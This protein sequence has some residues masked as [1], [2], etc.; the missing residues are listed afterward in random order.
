[1]EFRVSCLFNIT[2][3]TIYLYNKY[4]QNKQCTDTFFINRLIILTF[5][6]SNLLIRNYSILIKIIWIC[7]FFFSRIYLQINDLCRIKRNCRKVNERNHVAAE[8]ISMWMVIVLWLHHNR[9]RQFIWNAPISGTNAMH[10]Q[11]NAKTP[12]THS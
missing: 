6:F 12:A 9:I 7:V 3:I 5:K 10:G 4:L 8:I 1:M 11:A 2:I